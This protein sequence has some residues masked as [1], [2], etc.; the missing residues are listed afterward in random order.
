M[1]PFDEDDGEPWDINKLETVILQIEK[2]ALMKGPNVDNS[3]G[4]LT[5]LDRDEWAKVYILE[6][7]ESNIRIKRFTTLALLFC[8]HNV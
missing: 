5:T 3:I 7:L 8:S 6:L 4:V 2:V 1:I